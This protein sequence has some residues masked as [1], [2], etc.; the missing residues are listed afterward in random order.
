[1]LASCIA[2]EAN[3]NGSDSGACFD[4]N[5]IIV[6]D[7]MLSHAQKL[8]EALV[9][10]PSAQPDI[11]GDRWQTI[12]LSGIEFDAMNHML[13]DTKEGRDL[14]KRSSYTDP[15]QVLW[16]KPTAIVFVNYDHN[17]Y[18]LIVNRIWPFD[19]WGLAVD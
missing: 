2:K 8:K 1:M 17:S 14:I 11:A 12:I 15:T 3:K 6:N 5:A 19:L 10:A 16:P 13:I 7:S 18:Q 9:K 4:S